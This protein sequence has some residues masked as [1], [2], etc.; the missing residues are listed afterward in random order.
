M[1]LLGA[2]DE[3]Q[4][5]ISTENRRFRSNWGSLTQNFRQRRSSHQP[6]FLSQN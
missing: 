1:F 6:F 3:A 2:T 4:R 5:A